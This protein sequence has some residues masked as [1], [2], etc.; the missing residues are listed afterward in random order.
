MIQRNLPADAAVETGKDARDFVRL[1][2]A[3]SMGGACMECVIDQSTFR[4]KQAKPSDIL[5]ILMQWRV[6]VLYD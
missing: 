5:E 6:P 1:L 2:L 3:L 4:A